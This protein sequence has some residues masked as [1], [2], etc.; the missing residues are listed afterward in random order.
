[1]SRTLRGRL[2]GCRTQTLYV[3][4]LRDKSAEGSSAA[5]ARNCA[6]QRTRLLP[7]DAARAWAGI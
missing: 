2:V 7:G 6:W 3:E 5:G 4:S 1:M